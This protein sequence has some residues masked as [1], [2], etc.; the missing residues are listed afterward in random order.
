MNKTPHWALEFNQSIRWQEALSR[1]NTWHVGGVAECYFEPE[2]RTQ[3]QHFL[4]VLPSEWPIHWLGLGSNV[5]IRDG[6]LKGVVISSLKLNALKRLDDQNV[7]AEAGVPCARLARECVAWGLGPAAFWV[8]IPGT[9]G[10][11]LAM[12][13]GAWDGETWT[14][15]A[16]VEIINRQGCL[17]LKPATAFGASYRQVTGL[18]PQEWFIAARFELLSQPESEAERMRALLDE[19]RQKQPIGAWSGGSTFKNP[20][21]D[22]AARLIDAS[23]L[24][25]LR[26]G[27][28]MVSDKHANFIVN[29]GQA[30][31][32]D[33][34]NLIGI[35]ID[36]VE[37]SHGV[38]LQ[39]EVRIVGEPA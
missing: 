9:V 32:A 29:E 13:A 24:K 5:L 17:S 31:A 34:E 38:R 26:V 11:A 22:F 8:G 23:G 15:V 4:G 36:R 35:I 19:R 6:G 28:A 2:S 7:S 16:E 37:R 33:I 12:N 25:G 3:L 20:P 14:H 10:G 27:G 30:S 18:E 1:H 39:P 21:A